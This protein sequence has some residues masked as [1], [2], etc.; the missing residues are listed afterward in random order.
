[1]KA[2]EMCQQKMW[3]PGCKCCAQQKVGCSAVELKK[4]GGEKKAEW[5]IMLEGVED[6]MAAPLMELSDRFLEQVE[7]M[8]KELGNINKG[9]WAL[10]AGVGKLMEAI[11]QI[12]KKEVEKVEKQT[13]MESVLKAEKQM[14]TELEEEESEDEEEEGDKEE[15]G[16]ED[17]EVNKDREDKKDEEEKEAE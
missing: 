17:K 7:S 11:E 2:E 9:I 4:K 1:V 14:E 13:E 8:V 12:E 6:E 10:V 3:G 16:V 15:K 5:R